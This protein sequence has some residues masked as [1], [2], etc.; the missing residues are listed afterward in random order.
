M[1]VFRLRAVKTLGARSAV[2]FRKD[3]Y[4]DA[5]QGDIGA[6]IDTLGRENEGAQR[7]LKEA[8]GAEYISLQPK[9]LKVN[10][11]GNCAKHRGAEA[12]LR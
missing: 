5:V 9:V 6:V 7:M 2:D 11:A 1:V 8:K 3:S 10:T 4:S 12:M